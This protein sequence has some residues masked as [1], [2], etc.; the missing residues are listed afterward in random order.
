MSANVRS[1][2]FSRLQIANDLASSINGR[3]R[4]RSIRVSLPGWHV[5]RSPKSEGRQPRRVVARKDPIA[6]GQVR[7]QGPSPGGTQAFELDFL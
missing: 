7:T 2:L 3:G 4:A 1:I 6:V 5:D